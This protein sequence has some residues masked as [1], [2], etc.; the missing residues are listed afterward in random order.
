MAMAIRSAG[1]K[2]D[3]SEVMFKVLF[4]LIVIILMANAAMCIYLL[5]I[6]Y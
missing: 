3:R 4:T 1:P 2:S 6:G 5:Y